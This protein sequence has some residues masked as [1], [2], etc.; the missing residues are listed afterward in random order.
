MGRRDR[1]HGDRVLRVPAPLLEAVARVDRKALVRGVKALNEGLTRDRESFLGGAYLKDPAL[2]AAYAAYYLCV[3]APKLLPIL[4]ELQ[5]RGALPA[6]RP[7]RMLDLGGGPGT[8]AAA[9]ACWAGGAL[10]VV[11][12]DLLAENVRDAER[13]LRALGATAR[14]QIV[15][16]TKPL[17][18]A[19][20]PF[21]LV[22]MA[23]VVN[24][25]DAAHDPR[26]AAEVRALLAPDGVLVVLEPAAREPSRR[27]LA[28]RDR[29]V[30]SGW[31]IA[32]PCTH[33]AACPAL[34]EGDWCHGSWR[35]ERPDFVREVDEAVGTRRESLKATYFAALPAGPAAADPA[36]VRVVSER[37]DPKGLSRAIVCGAAGRA[38]L[39]L[40]NRDRTDGNA[41]F[42]DAARHDL[43]RLEGPLQRLG[44]GTL[45][46]GPE[47]RCERL[48]A[49][50]AED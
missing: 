35:F 50:P 37:F 42:A 20:A 4:D 12:T 7:L 26:L 9:V 17:A 1:R 5:A 27:A 45:R 49:G 44:D 18:V 46:L 47:A 13:L 24:E 22:V 10:D 29:L 15:D 43:L 14:G 21:D 40:R 30:A 34:A 38:T 2:R 11:C 8:A 3:N 33:A 36:L 28:F 19:G 32:L 25:I 48:P 16:L 41:A 23:N 31:G 39:E 6:R